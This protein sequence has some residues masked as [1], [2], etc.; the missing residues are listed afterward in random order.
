[1]LD[2]LYCVSQTRSQQQRDDRD[3]RYLIVRNLSK[4]TIADTVFNY[5]ARFASVEEASLN[6]DDDRLTPDGTATITFRQIPRDREK[7]ELLKQ[8]RIHG[9]VVYTEFAKMNAS[10]NTFKSY[11]ASN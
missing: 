2:L 5:F 9:H 10:Q 7:Q 6:L 8:H 3:Y 4:R 1:M 11:E